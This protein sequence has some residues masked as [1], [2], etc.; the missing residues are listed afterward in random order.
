MACISVSSAD[1]IE[2]IKEATGIYFDPVGTF[3]LSNNYLHI[4]VPIDIGY[5]QPHIDNIKSALGTARFL[6]QQNEL[7]VSKCHNFLQ[8]LTSRLDTISKDYSAISHLLPD[9]DKRSAWF[10]GIGSFFKQVIGTMDEDDSIKYNSAIQHLEN[11][12][13][14]LSSLLKDNILL[15]DTALK[16]YNETLKTIKNNEAQLGNA[17][18]KLS[19]LL[20]NVTHM[21]KGLYIESKMNEIYNELSSSLLTLSFR[22]DDIINAILFTKSH[23]IHPSI[24]TP[25]QLYEELTHSVKDLNKN[26]ELPISLSLDSIHTL[27]DLA[28]LSCYFINRKVVFVIKIPLVYKSEYVL[29]KPIIVPIP[30]DVDQPNSYAMIIPHCNHIAI[31]KDKITYVCLQLQEL[32]KCV[33]TINQI[34]VCSNL[35]IHSVQDMPICETEMLCKIINKLPQQCETKLVYGNIDIWQEL[36]NNKWLFVKSEPTKLTLECN[37]QITEYKLLGTGVISLQP[38]CK[39]Y[40][41]GREFTSKPYYNTVIKPI[42]S[43]FNLISDPCCDKDK[44]MLIKSKLK[45]LRLNDVHLEKLVT[46]SNH[47]LISDIDKIINEPSPFIKYE[48]HYPIITYCILILLLIFIFYKLCKK[49]GKCPT[50][51]TKIESN[52]LADDVQELEEIPAPRLRISP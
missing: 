41:K 26:S 3:K 21:P 38:E 30:H 28:Q 20:N 15:T 8:P 42:I 1:I 19:A 10:A 36:K 31:S 24:L 32:N 46:V 52:S 9:R 13:K 11:N 43:D 51:K 50:S 40:C 14:K 34:Y 44:F 5:I 29:Y 37:S 22:L 12:D 39:A 49:F 2:P 18:E 4:L 48:S 45:P 35:D 25:K 16:N 47:Q 6:C 23:S 27:I 17:I 33:K 7:S